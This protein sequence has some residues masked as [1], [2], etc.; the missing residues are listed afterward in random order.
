MEQTGFKLDINEKDL[1]LVCLSVE[2]KE[3]KDALHVR[4]VALGKEIKKVKSYNQLITAVSVASIYA[5]FKTYKKLEKAKD[6]IRQYESGE[7]VKTDND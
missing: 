4:A 7:E 3:L 1:A 6:F 5:L 2:N